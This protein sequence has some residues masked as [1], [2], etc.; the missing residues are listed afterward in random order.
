[1]RRYDDRPDESHMSDL[2][3]QIRRLAG[4]TADEMVELRREIHR[5]P[6]LGHEEFE[7]TK[8]VAHA[9][10]AAGIQTRSRITATGLI[11]DVGCER[12]IVGF[13]ADLDALPIEERTNVPYRSQVPG[14]MH[15]CGHDAHTAI[16]VGIARVLNQL[17]LPGTVRFVFQPAE[18]VFPGGAYDLV[19]EGVTDGMSSIM[20]FHVDP[21]MKA[22]KVGLRAGAITSSSDRFS[23]EVEGPGGHTARP[24]ETVDAIHAAAKV[25]TDL[26]ALL[27]R[28]VDARQP[29][30]V[31]FGQI[32]GGHVDN[33]IPSLVTLSGTCRAL[34][35]ELWDSLPLLV[36]RL[37]HEIVAPYG[38]KAVVRYQ[39]GIPPVVNDP[40]VTTTLERALTVALGDQAVGLTM[41]SL[42]A[43][44]FS[45]YL[46]VVPG[47]LVRLGVGFGEAARDLHSA[48]FDLDEAAIEVGIIGGAYG[49]IELLAA[50]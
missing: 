42:G 22:G 49:L 43:E 6:E 12:P 28:L 45:R 4:Q 14:A 40:H 30:A 35:R 50:G 20:A 11:A 38:A 39:R 9:L 24:H 2:L 17:D 21:S 25:V 10:N 23:I 46:E 44:D 19:R 32:H 31:V 1:M 3:A 37:A 34:D 7:T 8:R 5:H 33:V 27:D 13:R 36:E 26:P 18:E 41:A 29:F 47:S 48:S 15:A 16:G